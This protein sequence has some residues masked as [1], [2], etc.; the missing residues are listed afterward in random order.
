MVLPFSKSTEEFR[1]RNSSV[2]LVEQPL[3]YILLTGFPPS[4]EVAI[5]NVGSVAEFTPVS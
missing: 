5:L 3:F 4:T 2:G 1:P